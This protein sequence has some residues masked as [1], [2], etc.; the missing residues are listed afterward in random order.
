MLLVIQQT[1]SEVKTDCL[2][3]HNGRV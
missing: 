2:T 3:S 1:F